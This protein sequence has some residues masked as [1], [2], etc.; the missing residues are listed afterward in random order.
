MFEVI[1]SKTGNFIWTYYFLPILLLAATLLS[2]GCKGFQF[3]HFGFIIKNTIGKAFSRKTKNVNSLSPFQAASTALGSTVG[4]GNIVGTAQAICMGG[5]G[6]LFWL[7]AAALIGMIVKYAEI[8]LAI[9]YRKNTPGF[10]PM[11]YIEH[12]LNSKFLSQIYAMLANNQLDYLD[13][14]DQNGIRQSRLN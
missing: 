8:V 6:A 1:I 7:W 14:L 10:G 2:I 9:K 12:G 13:G 3:R 11:D 4:T 5:P